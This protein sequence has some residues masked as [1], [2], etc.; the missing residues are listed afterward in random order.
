M[1][2]RIREIMSINVYNIGFQYLAQS[3]NFMFVHP[4]SLGVCKFSLESFIRFT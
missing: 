1:G 4:S 2:I 3:R